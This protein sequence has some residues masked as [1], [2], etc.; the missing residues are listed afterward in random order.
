MLTPPLS[1][2]QTPTP[3]A[4]QCPQD[5]IPGPST[6]DPARSCICPCLPLLLAVPAP[7]SSLCLYVSYK[8]PTSRQLKVPECFTGTHSSTVE[9]SPFPP[10]PPP[11]VSTFIP[12]NPTE[13]SNLTREN[14]FPRSFLSLSD[15]LG[16]SPGLPQHP[17]LSQMA[18]SATRFGL[19][20]LQGAWP[21]QKQQDKGTA[22]PVMLTST[23]QAPTMSQVLH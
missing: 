14:P 8:E 13:N 17:A 3:V 20:S 2:S 5:R 4:P 19:S 15:G 22:V 9:T 7:A 18:F 1:C 11:T 12:D 6:E 16:P 10:P 23:S 21:L